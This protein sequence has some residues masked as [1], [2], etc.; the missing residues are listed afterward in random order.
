MYPIIN[1][2]GRNV[3]SYALFSILGFMVCGLVLFLTRKY[4]KLDLDNTV[5]IALI[6]IGG[7]FIGGHFMYGIVNLPLLFE[8]IGKNKLTF[9]LL[10]TA[11][12]KTFGGMVFYGGFLG[13]MLALTIYSRIS[14]T[15]TDC[16]VLDIY[17]F[18]T[19]L[20]HTFGRIGCF[21]AGCCFGIKSSFGF[22]VSSNPSVPEIN[23]VNRFPV[24]LLEASFNLIIFF[25]VITVFKR[26]KLKGKLIYFY[27]LLYSPA[28]FI[29]EFLRGDELRGIYFGLSTSQWIS[30]FLILFASIMLIIKK[31]Q[32]HIS[33]II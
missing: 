1:I 29:T 22:T 8:I 13:G 5:I 7:L 28:R 33:R 3:G 9:N 18:L 25:I 24:A 21:F 6:M 15:K 32:Q 26:Q 2:L 20:F 4:H 23:G 27:M 12:N 31:S 16:N 11:L 10:I 30:I 17:A 14:K 19:P